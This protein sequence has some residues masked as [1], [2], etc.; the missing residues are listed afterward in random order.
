MERNHQKGNGENL[1]TSLDIIVEWFAV[2][3]VPVAF[4]AWCIGNIII[5]NQSIKNLRRIYQDEDQI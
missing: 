1:M 3:T 4:I 2:A 5:N